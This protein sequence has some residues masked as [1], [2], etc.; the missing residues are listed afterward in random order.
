[1]G[2]NCKNVRTIEKSI[3]NFNNKEIERKG[4]KNILIQILSFFLRIAI[5]CVILLLLLVLT[6][7]ILIVL[8][9]NLFCNGNLLIKIPK[10]WL[11]KNKDKTN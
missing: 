7:I 3:T 5:K 10:K 6:P 1:M 11:R 4:F 8:I 2:C 9:T